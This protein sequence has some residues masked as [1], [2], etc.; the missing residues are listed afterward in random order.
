MYNL[1]FSRKFHGQLLNLLSVLYSILAKN[2]VQGSAFSFCLIQ[3]KGTTLA[4]KHYK[5]NMDQKNHDRWIQEV[6]IMKTL[7]HPNVV[8]AF[9]V[10]EQL[11]VH[12]SN[13]PVLAMEYCSG[14]DLR[15]V[16][17]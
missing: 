10:P 15:T 16:S 11:K 1:R 2:H 4:L 13:L 6:L 3:E 17:V 5:G 7:K 9:D 12:S 14:G 8:R